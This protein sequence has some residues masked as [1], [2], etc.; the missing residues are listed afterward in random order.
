MLSDT[1]PDTII[2]WVP[3]RLGHL[4]SSRTLGVQSTDLL[5]SC[6]VWGEFL[7]DFDFFFFCPITPFALNS[8]DFIYIAASSQFLNKNLKR[9]KKNLKRIPYHCFSIE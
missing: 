8:N 9:K 1:C 2:G 7:N 6:C 3:T 5:L 4:E